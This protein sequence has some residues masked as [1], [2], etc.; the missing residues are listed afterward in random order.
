[1]CF[2]GFLAMLKSSSVLL[3]C[4]WVVEARSRDPDPRRVLFEQVPTGGDQL[5]SLKQT[6]TGTVLAARSRNPDPRRVPFS[7]LRLL[8]SFYSAVA[9]SVCSQRKFGPRDVLRE[10]RQIVSTSSKAT[11]CVVSSSLLMHSAPVE[12]AALTRH[13][14]EKNIAAQCPRLLDCMFGPERSH[15]NVVCRPCVGSPHKRRLL[16][17]GNSC[18][19]GTCWRATVLLFRHGP[20]ILLHTP[21]CSLRCGSAVRSVDDR[22]LASLRM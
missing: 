11:M 17:Y 16:Q 20:T 12:D 13:C 5:G 1:M 15:L 7:R 8:L 2:P 4:L 21:S 19:I 22:S 10:H 18:H 9:L 14:V 3:S 6:T